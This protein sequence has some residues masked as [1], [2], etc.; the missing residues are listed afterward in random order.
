MNK[1]PDATPELWVSALFVIDT[2]L[3]LASAILVIPAP[4]ASLEP[5]LRFAA[6]KR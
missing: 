3:P 6:L 4:R 5:A 1:A 2:Q